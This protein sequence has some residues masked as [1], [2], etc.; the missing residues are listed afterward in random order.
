MACWVTVGNLRSLIIYLC[1]NCLGQDVW[2]EEQERQQTTEVCQDGTA[3]NP[4]GTQ[5]RPSGECYLNV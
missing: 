2:H 3:T 4:A 5:I 1:L